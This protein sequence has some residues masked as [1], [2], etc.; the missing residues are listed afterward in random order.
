MITV[1]CNL[2]FIITTTIII[3]IIMIT[4]LIMSSS[5]Q[6]GRNGQPHFEVLGKAVWSAIKSCFSIRCANEFAIKSDINSTVE[7]RHQQQF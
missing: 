3:I 1:L 7:S 6:G 5:L 4:I 2:L